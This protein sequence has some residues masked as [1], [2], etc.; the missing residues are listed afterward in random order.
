ME[1][2]NQGGSAV[3]DHLP[4]VVLNDRAL[5]L[6]D[7]TA[8]AER[9]H[10]AT[11]L[12][13]LVRMGERQ[14]FFHRNA[15]LRLGGL[16]LSSSVHSPLV[17]EAEDTGCAMVA[18][19]Y[20]GSAQVTLQQQRFD[21]WPQQGLLY[22]PGAAFEAQTGFLQEVLIH[23][24]PAQLALSAAAI[25]GGAHGPRPF[26]R[27]L[28]QPRLVHPRSTLEQD[29]LTT[30]RRTLTTL[31]APDLEAAGGFAALGIEDLL[32]RLL[33]LLLFPELLRAQPSSSPH[34]VPQPREQAFT[35]LLEWMKAHLH[36]PITLT[37]MELRSAYSRRSLQ[38]LFQ[39]RF[40]CSPMQWLKAQRLEAARQALLHPEADDT[41]ASIAR[42]HGFADL[43]GFAM[44]F[45]RRYGLLPSGV[46][47]LGRS[48]D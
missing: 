6:T 7:A 38:I 30:L 44:G 47:R 29:L 5:V 22:L 18:L 13:G 32:L 11:P 1:T 21:L 17:L 36:T 24:D 14:G 2:H 42:R 35:D 31:D 45:R 41:V 34:P 20:A 43:S 27:R 40:G 9:I 33:A 28:R 48:P 3:S 10:A 25:A 8:L 4:L 39:E 23:L 16:S 19:A 12:R 46:L 15:V 26:L 37:Q